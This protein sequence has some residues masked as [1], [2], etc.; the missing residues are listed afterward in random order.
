MREVGGGGGGGG[1]GGGGKKKRSV[2]VSANGPGSAV[3][4]KHSS[5]RI[6]TIGRMERKNETEG[7][8]QKKSEGGFF[9][10]PGAHTPFL[11]LLLLLSLLLL[12]F[13]LSGGV[14]TT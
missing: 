6:S 3:W 11:Q 13:N 1:R 4:S 8:Q 14:L 10:S 7:E 5:Q 2:L 9:F 12:H